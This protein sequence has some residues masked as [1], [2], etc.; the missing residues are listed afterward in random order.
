MLIIM[1]LIHDPTHGPITDFA[2]S[3]QVVIVDED[4]IAI[5]SPLRIHVRIMWVLTEKIWHGFAILTSAM[6]SSNTYR[7]SLYF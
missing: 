7:G 1:M 2:K 4:Q 5:R 6:Y 3:V